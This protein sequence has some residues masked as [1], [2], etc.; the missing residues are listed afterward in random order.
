MMAYREGR[1]MWHLLIYNKDFV[2][3][4]ERKYEI[5]FEMQQHNGM[6]FTKITWFIAFKW[7]N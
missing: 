7:S 5:F 6:I 4:D 3:P 1:N 2:I